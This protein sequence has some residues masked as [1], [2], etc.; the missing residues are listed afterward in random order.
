MKQIVEVRTPHM[1]KNMCEVRYNMFVFASV[2]SPFLFPSSLFCLWL[3]S[4]GM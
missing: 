4:M 3:C 1:V 2:S